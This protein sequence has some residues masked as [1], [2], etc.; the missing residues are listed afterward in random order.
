MIRHGRKFQG[1][2]KEAKVVLDVVAAAIAVAVYVCFWMIPA[3]R[4]VGN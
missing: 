3:S 1:S 4:M 2:D